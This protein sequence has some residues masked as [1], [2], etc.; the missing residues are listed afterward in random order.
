MNELKTK[1]KR[2]LGVSWSIRFCPKYMQD[3]NLLNALRTVR[4]Y[5]VLTLCAFM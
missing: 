2:T 4:V 3:Q 5:S 1:A